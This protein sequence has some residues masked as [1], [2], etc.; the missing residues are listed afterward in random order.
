MH[1]HDRFG[2]G[3]YRSLHLFWVEAPTVRQDV[4]KHRCGP[5]VH[6]RRR[7][8]DPVGIGHDH[9]ITSSDSQGMHAHVQGTGATAGGNGVFHT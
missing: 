1:R 7:G 4:H 9:V 6:D 2:L 3:C 5:Q 8:G